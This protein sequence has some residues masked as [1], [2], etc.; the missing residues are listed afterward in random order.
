MDYPTRCKQARD[1]KHGDKTLLTGSELEEPPYPQHG[2]TWGGVWKFNAKNLTLVSLA[3][4]Y[5]YDVDLERIKSQQ[6]IVRT[7]GHLL[8][9]KTSWC[10]GA[11]IGHFVQALFDLTE[12]CG[13]WHGDF[14][15]RN[16]VRKN[17]EV[18]LKGGSKNGQQATAG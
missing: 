3:S 15:L 14:D 11:N 2:D 12:G 8:A 10:H 17:R 18:A 4:G 13:E 5:G 1:A 16:I 7:I 6:D 9:T